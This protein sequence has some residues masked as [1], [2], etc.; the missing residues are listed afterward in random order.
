MWH[1]LVGGV[2]VSKMETKR[3]Q[4]MATTSREAKFQAVSYSLTLYVYSSSHW[5][6]SLFAFAF[7]PA[8][9]SS[10]EEVQVFHARFALARLLLLNEKEEM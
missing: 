4:G 1:E 3:F 6:S 8:V 5:S 10:G 9:H 7:A 2:P